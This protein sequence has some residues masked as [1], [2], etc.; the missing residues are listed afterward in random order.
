VIS[1]RQTVAYCGLPDV[2]L[3]VFIFATGIVN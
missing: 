3:K 1:Y 2:E